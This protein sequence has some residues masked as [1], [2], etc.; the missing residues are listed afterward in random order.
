MEKE[1]NETRA[2]RNVAL[3]KKYKLFSYDFLFYYAVEVLFFTIVK[4]FSMSQIMYISAIYTFSAFFWQLFGSLIV[5]KLGLK[6]SIILGNCLVSINIL[7][8]ILSSSFWMYNFANFFLALG[9][10]L[11]SLSEGSLLYSSLKKLGKRAE[12]SKIEGKSNSKFYYFDA[13]SSILSGF[14]FVINGYLPFICCFICTLFSLSMSFKFKDLKK[15]ADYEESASIKETFKGLKEVTSNKRSKAILMFAF[16]FWGVISVINTL[17]KAIILDIGIN[18]QY[19]TMV[20]CLVTIFVGFGSR[21]VYGIEKITKNK[22]LTVFSYFLLISGIIVGVIGM[23]N[24][25]NLMTLSILLILL[26]IIGLVQGAYRV[27]IKKYVLSFTTSQIRIKITSAY[28]IVENLGKCLILF[29][30]GFILEFTTNSVSCLIFSIISLI[31]ITIILMYMKGKLGLK[32]EQYNP[33]D[34]NYMK[35]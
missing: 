15:E 23:Y 27:A 18:E 19:S 9:F 33:E 3:Y 20:V 32:P 4:G 17:Y 24:K 34:I 11:K 14:L 28:Y 7:L 22:T 1:I 30:S 26:A 6:N 29:L 31:V 12:F 5:E 16:V 21:G 8:Y 35:I 2:K 25:L 13:I 10:S